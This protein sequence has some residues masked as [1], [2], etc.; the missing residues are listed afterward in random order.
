MEK[1]C[2]ANFKKLIKVEKDLK[3][4]NKQVKKK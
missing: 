2:I 1:L 4:N 3:I